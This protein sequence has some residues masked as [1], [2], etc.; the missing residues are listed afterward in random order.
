MSHDARAGKPVVTFDGMELRYARAVLYQSPY[1]AVTLDLD[2]SARPLRCDQG[3]ARDVDRGAAL[4]MSV[5]PGPN[6][7]FFAGPSP[8][9][10]DVYFYRVGEQESADL[11]LSGTTLQL[12]PFQAKAKAALSGQI[13]IPGHGGGTFKTT[14]CTI[15]HVKLPT[16][17][18]DPTDTLQVIIDGKTWRP[19]KV[20]AFRQ[21]VDKKPVV[22]GLVVADAS[23]TC[24]LSSSSI[25]TITLSAG[26]AVAH[27]GTIQPT[28]ATITPPTGDATYAGITSLAWLRLDI[29]ERDVRGSFAARQ[30]AAKGARW[31][32]SG[33]FTAE[34]CPAQ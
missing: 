11:Q 29:S 28:S 20:L 22:V 7:S 31:E 17:P 15:K 26:A 23:H 13:T 19:A 30:D 6:N 14:L 18:P 10:I 2:L 27:P 3:T 24:D 9:A 1:G 33:R 16:P 34:L 21:L 5:H 8:F 32:A 12:A 25:G 4:T